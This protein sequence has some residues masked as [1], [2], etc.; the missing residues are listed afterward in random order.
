MAKDL[1]SVKRL[2][3]RYHRLTERLINE[4]RDYTDNI[5]CVFCS[6]YDGYA[7]AEDTDN[8]EIKHSRKCPTRQAEKLKA[9][10]I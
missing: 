2:V 8:N 10:E 4:G 5:D 9:V 7:S 6:G 1:R 3:S